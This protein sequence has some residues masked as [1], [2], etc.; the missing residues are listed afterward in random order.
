MTQ[1]ESLG[2]WSGFKVGEGRREALDT[3][4]FSLQLPLGHN[5]PGSCF[6]VFVIVVSNT[7]SYPH[8]AHHAL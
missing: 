8:L 4:V 2:I 1:C 5:L 3:G 6:E 7:S